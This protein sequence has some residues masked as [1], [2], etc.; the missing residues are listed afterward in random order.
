MS[1]Q[2]ER[3][4]DGIFG[5]LIG[6][7]LG[8]PYEFHEPYEIPNSK[9]IEYNPPVDFDRA[10]RGTPPGTWSDDGAQALALLDS[11]LKKR[12]LDLVHFSGNLLKWQSHGEWAVDRAVFDIGLQTSRAFDAIRSG[13][14]P[15]KSGPAT[16]WDN[17]NGSLMRCLPIALWHEGSDE[18]LIRVAQD[19]SLP[20]HGH[21]RAQV[22]C[23]MYCLWAR[24][25]I[26]NSPTPWDDAMETLLK[27]YQAGSPAS[28]ELKYILEWER[29]NQPS[30]TGYVV[31][32]LFSAKQ[33]N[34][35][36]SYE[37]VIKYSIQLGH[38]TDT[39]AC[40]A[41]GIAGLRFGHKSIPKRWLVGLRGQSILESLF[42]SLT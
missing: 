9:E 36:T 33:A 21:L 27:H 8:V 5:L 4:K 42:D 13:S 15:N 32:S 40:I 17:G 6:D 16:E 29:S 30:G 23:A 25:I 7:A 10:H 3:I 31:D 37:D 18:D 22:C 19:Q 34:L 41:G 1:D 24:R 26:E 28:M 14:P 12:Q 39:T 35:K 11:L 38:D 20:T 2:S